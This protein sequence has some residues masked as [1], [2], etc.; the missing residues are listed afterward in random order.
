VSTVTGGTGITVNNTD[1]DNPVVALSS[2]S[3]ASLAL[4]DSA[5]QSSAIGIS[6]QGY[7]ATLDDWALIDPADKADAGA[8]GSSG[9]TMATD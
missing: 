1:P 6:V 5:L 2:A 8:I 7:S 9:L 4:A 3:Q